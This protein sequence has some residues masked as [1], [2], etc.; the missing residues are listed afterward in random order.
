MSV[1]IPLIKLVVLFWLS[2][3]VRFPHRRLLRFRTRLHRLVDEINPW[4]FLDPFIVALNASMLAYPGIADVRPAPGVLAF[5]LVVV[6]TM[7]AS[8]LFDAR[9]MWDAVERKAEQE[10]R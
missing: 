9:L 1:G 7:I 3:S 4:S 6:L 5:S 8:R 2:L 10:T